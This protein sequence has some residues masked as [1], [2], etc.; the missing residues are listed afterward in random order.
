MGDKESLIRARYAVSVLKVA[1]NTPRQEAIT[2]VEGLSKD[3]LDM[4]SDDAIANARAGALTACEQLLSALRIN[5][6]TLPRA[7]DRAFS[8]AAQW[9]DLAQ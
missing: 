9:V 4:E 6:A 3:W 5:P 7:W 2:L 1:K 8:A